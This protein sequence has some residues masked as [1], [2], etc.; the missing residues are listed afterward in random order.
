M[1]Q[2]NINMKY[3]KTLCFSL[4]LITISCNDVNKT[5]SK[6]LVNKKDTIS[7]TCDTNLREFVKP[8]DFDENNKKIVFLEYDNY[9]VY[10][11]L[12]T[13]KYSVVKNKNKL[14]L[15]SLN[16]FSKIGRSVQVLDKKNEIIYY[17][18]DFKKLSDKSEIPKPQLF[19]CGNVPCWKLVI[20]NKDS[21]YFVKKKE[22]HSGS[23]NKSKWLDIDSISEKGI[24]EIHFLHTGKT[25]EYDDNVRASEIIIIKYEKFS[26]VRV[27]KKSFYFES[28]DT[29][30]NIKV[31]CHNHFGY[32]GI[33]KV[34]YKELGIFEYNLAPFVLDD[35]QRG[36][37]DYQGNEYL[38]QE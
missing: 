30:N 5:E 13:K 21:F 37:I 15:D 24:K 9:T 17:T 14:L 12:E 20:E 32:F 23:F 28:I 36:Y 26:A 31:K 6:K 38:T 2:I 25:L 4:F 8:H 34:K 27:D 16:Y 1:R 7:I 29:S 11:N 35:G 22:G 3:F 10:K 18:Q 19:F 33:S